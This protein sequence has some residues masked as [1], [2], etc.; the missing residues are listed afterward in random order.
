MM[1]KYLKY[2]LAL[3]ALLTFSP[4]ANVEAAILDNG[5][6]LTEATTT[7]AAPNSPTGSA[8]LKGILYPL[9]PG[10]NPSAA[11]VYFESQKVGTTGVVLHPY[12]SSLAN[13]NFE[14][15]I[16]SLDCGA[17]YKFWMF[18]FPGDTLI[19]VD[20]VG[21]S[22]QPGFSLPVV[23]ASTPPPG[24]S[25]DQMAPALAGAQVI[26]GVNWGNVSAT[27]HSINISNA[28]IIPLVYGGSKTFKVEYGT[29]TANGN[30]EPA[31]G[32]TF[33][34]YSQNITRNPPYNFSLQIGALAPNTSYYFNLWEINGN[35]E[36]NLFVYGFKQT[37]QLTGSQ[38]LLYTFPDA[39]SVH[40]YGN[41]LNDDGQALAGLPIDIEIRATEDPNSTLVNNIS[42]VVGGSNIINGNGFYEYTFTGLTPNTIYYLFLR[43]STTNAL[44]M[45]PVEFTMPSSYTPPT[46][47]PSPNT[48]FSGGLVA[49]D[50]ITNPCDFNSLIDSI[51]RVI[52]FLIVFVAFP[53]VALVIAWAGIKL[54]TSGGSEEAK[55]GAK[56]II[57]KVL[58]GFIVALL[59]W[60]IIKLILVT[61]GYVPTGTLWSVF[62]TSPN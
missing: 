40:V 42:V 51:N 2:F 37:S 53:V 1:I 20:T 21:G 41:L 15:T 4:F 28:H 26:A 48:T 6:L 56:S 24:S 49:C 18:E 13:G 46:P 60:S 39:T 9:V 14:Q 7:S 31:G 17:T 52:N 25:S 58:I 33:L 23:C 11:Q 8:T 34:G 32:G 44:I 55:T 54:I 22:L 45:G 12:F 5:Y 50:G 10:D 30:N 3:L 61:L 43:N 29:G 27:D 62:G 16:A 38:G 36:G 57:K 19:Q 47:T 59:C 35:T